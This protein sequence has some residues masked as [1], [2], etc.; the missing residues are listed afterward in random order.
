MLNYRADYTFETNIIDLR[1][2]KYAQLLQG[3]QIADSQCSKGQH[4]PYANYMRKKQ[5]TGTSHV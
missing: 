3:Q 4:G 2:S 1:K 5:S